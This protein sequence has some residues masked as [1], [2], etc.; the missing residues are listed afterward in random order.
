ML[1]VEN[2]PAQWE[3]RNPDSPRIHQPDE[4]QINLGQEIPDRSRLTP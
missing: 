2:D 4:W 1:D 3:P